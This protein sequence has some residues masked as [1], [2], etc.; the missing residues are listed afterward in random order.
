MVDRRDVLKMGMGATIAAG[1]LPGLGATRQDEARGFFL[2]GLVGGAEVPPVETDAGGGALFSLAENGQDL[3][4]TLSINTLNNLTQAHIHR[5]SA[6]ENGEVVAWL[7]PGPFAER[8]ELLRGRTDGTIAE[9]ML[10]A[11]NLRGPLEGRSLDALLDLFEDDDAY[12]NVHTE[13]HPGGE[14]RGQVL[15]LATVAACAG[16]G[17]ET[18]PGEDTPDETDGET[19]VGET[20]TATLSPTPEPTET[21][22]ATETETESGTT[23]TTSA[24]V[25]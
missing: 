19:T 9:G 21:A 7:Y 25:R 15:P 4:Y 16:D 17:E 22:G 6:G 18:T 24:S 10:T 20:E 8:G 1:L 5:G 2:A 13:Q 11:D 14:I 23:E 3:L 12:V